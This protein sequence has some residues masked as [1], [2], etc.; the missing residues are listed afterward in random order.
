M[1][2]ISAMYFYGLL[3]LDGYGLLFS[4]HTIINR[5]LIELLN[6]HFMLPLKLKKM[7]YE[8]VILNEKLYMI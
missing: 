7:D 1:I 2:Y 4:L 5:M 3:D 6:E 8:A